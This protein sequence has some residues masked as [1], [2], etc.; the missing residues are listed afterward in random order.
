MNESVFFSQE[1][2]GP[3]MTDMLFNM[4]RKWQIYD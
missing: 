3:V 2:L 1:K 4:N